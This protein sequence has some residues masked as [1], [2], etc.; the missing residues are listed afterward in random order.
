MNTN[1]QK[2]LFR[3]NCVALIVAF[4]MLMPACGGGGSSGGG[5]TNPLTASFTPDNLNPGAN[6][7]SM[8][9]ASAGANVSVSIQVTGINDFFGAGFRVTYNPATVN[10]TGYDATG[11]LLNAYAGGKDINA[12]ELDPSNR[13]T[14]IVVATIQDASQPAGLDV[15]GTQTLI[16]LNFQATTT[17]ASN[18]IDFAAPQDVQICAVQGQAG[19][20]VSGALSW[21]GGAIRASR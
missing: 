11:S 14:I 2:K 3:L 21:D 18:P 6:T 17:T 4:G 19:N 16:K 1:R 7:I 10:F 12:Q 9:G 15:V 5:V 13:G 20:E 8:A